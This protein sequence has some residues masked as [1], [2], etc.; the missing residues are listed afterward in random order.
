[1][2]GSPRRRDHENDA[3]MRRERK[4]SQRTTSPL[5]RW[6]FPGF[7]LGLLLAAAPLQRSMAQPAANAS[8]QAPVER[9]DNALLAVMKT[10]SQADFH[11][12]YQTLK[13]IITQTFDLPTVLAE[14]VGMAWATIPAA[15]RAKLLAAFRRYTVS[16]YVS[17]F[18]SYNGQS[19]KMLPTV[20]QVF[21]GEAVVATRLIRR[22]KAPVKLSY[23][24]RQGPDGWQ[25][26]DVLTDGTISRV[27]VQ[28]S[29]FGQLLLSG[30]VPALTVALDHKVSN[31]SGGIAG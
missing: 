3:I 7:V 16:S 12:R 6:R 23:V 8:P 20:R 27:A 30:G 4:V 17:S 19:F 22:N 1:M 14:S 21:S 15:Q 31:L 2:L 26:V 28:R 18:D 11:Q 9:L 24:V 13:P 10:G 29:D 25:I 5:R